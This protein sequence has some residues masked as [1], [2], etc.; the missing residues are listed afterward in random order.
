MV[1][2]YHGQRIERKEM[3]IERDECTFSQV[4][5]LGEGAH[6]AFTLILS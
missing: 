2:Q 5:H 4:S 3:N 1:D 6:T